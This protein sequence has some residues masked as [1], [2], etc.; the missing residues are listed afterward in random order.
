MFHDRKFTAGKEKTEVRQMI[1]PEG[2]GNVL[3]FLK[4]S[5]ES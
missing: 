1:Y 2:E 4:F 5:L 3:M